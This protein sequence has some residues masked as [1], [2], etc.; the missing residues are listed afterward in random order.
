MGRLPHEAPAEDPVLSFEGPLQIAFEGPGTLDNSA[1]GV[2]TGRA[3]PE[4][5]RLEDESAAVVG[6]RQR[7]RLGRGGDRPGRFQGVFDVDPVV[8]QDALQ[9]QRDLRTAT[10]D[11][12]ASGPVVGG[13]QEHRVLPLHPEVLQDV[14][15]ARVGP[16]PQ[17]L[18]AL[19]HHPLVRRP[20]RARQEVPVRLIARAV[21]EW[22]VTL[23]EVVAQDP[24]LRVVQGV[25]EE[26]CDLPL[27]RVRRRAARR[28]QQLREPP[29][30]PAVAAAPS[31]HVREDGR[32]RVTHGRVGRPPSFSTTRS[33]DSRVMSLRVA[34]EGLCGPALTAPSACGTARAAGG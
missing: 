13:L 4:F 29:A 2:E 12:M 8:A 15:S 20:H 14:G 3:A 28:L 22:P 6:R 30:A 25:L 31:V 23:L 26:P 17:Q 19:A 21:L 34:M 9:P 5:G 24:A 32:E 16:A 1:Q 18:L 10:R 11:D 27:P 33:C 7:D